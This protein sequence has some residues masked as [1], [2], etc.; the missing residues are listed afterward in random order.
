M[1]ETS[2]NIH[3]RRHRL[4][5]VGRFTV[6]LAVSGTYCLLLLGAP[7][8][9]WKAYLPEAAYSTRVHLHELLRTAYDVVGVHSWGGWELRA[10]TYL[11]LVGAAVPWLVLTL[12]RRGRPYDLGLRRPNRLGLRLIAVGYLVALPLLVWLAMKPALHHFYLPHLHRVGAMAFALYFLCNML[13]EHF[14]IHGLLLAVYRRGFRW[15]PPPELVV[16]EDG[17]RLVRVLQWLGLSQPTGDARG[18]AGIARWVGLPS[19]CVPGIAGSTM[20]FGL[21]HVGK[22]PRELLLSIPGGLALAFLAYRT[23][24]WLTPFL[25][26]LAT[27]GTA[28]LLMMWTD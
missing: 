11:M 26:H 14:I 16:G 19:G 22:D 7:P 9:S 23:N 27:A 6:T 15:P 12:F 1:S 25:L 20:I 24:S 2:T 4:W 13:S 28:C 8:A 5:G 18:G 17:R 3:P 10:G 21:L